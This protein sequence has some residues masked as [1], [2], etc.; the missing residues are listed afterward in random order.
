MVHPDSPSARQF[1]VPSV[2][3]ALNISA[4]SDMLV[5]AALRDRFEASLSRSAA[6]HP[7]WQRVRIRTRPE[8]WVLNVPRLLLG[9]DDAQR[10]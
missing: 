9:A 7:S 1:V 5:R 8:T 2:G 6:R 4:G 3:F 10:G